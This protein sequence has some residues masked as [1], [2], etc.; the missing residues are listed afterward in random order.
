MNIYNKHSTTPYT[1]NNMMYSI[2]LGI[3]ISIVVLIYIFQMNDEY[4]YGENDICNIRDGCY[5]ANS[6]VPYGETWAMV[7][8]HECNR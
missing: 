2:V 5:Y 4:L 3:A 8:E 6:Y 7:M 1:Y